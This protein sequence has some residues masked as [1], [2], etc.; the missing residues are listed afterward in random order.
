M[1][2]KIYFWVYTVFMV[3]G[4]IGILLWISKLTVSDWI[5]FVLGILLY[6]GLYAFVFRKKVFE[7]NWLVAIF[8][9]NALLIALAVLDWFVLNRQIEQAIP[10][11]QS[12]I[13]VSE[14]DML[15]GIL[16]SL[17]ALYAVYLLSYPKKSSKKK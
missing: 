1:W 11:L 9:S 13:P 3:L 2:W 14:T 12:G 6:I 4:V 5:S 17:P 16:I 10:F 7:T 8:W 15:I